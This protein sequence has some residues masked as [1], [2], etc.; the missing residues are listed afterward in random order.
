MHFDFDYTTLGHVTVDV[1]EDGSR[2]PGGTAFYSALQAARLGR[3][4]QI[5]TRGRAEELEALLEPYR[6]ELEVTVLA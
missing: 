2:Q 1:L 5:L 3:R 4:T 6:S